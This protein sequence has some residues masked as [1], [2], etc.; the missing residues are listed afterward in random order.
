M[1]LVTDPFTRTPANQMV[2]ASFITTAASCTL[3]GIGLPY[4]SWLTI[5]SGA[6]GT[7]NGLVVI[8]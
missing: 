7:G 4:A 8:S 1:F 6:S 2:S 5:Q 3:D